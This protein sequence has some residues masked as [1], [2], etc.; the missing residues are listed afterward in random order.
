[1]SFF[2]INLEYKSGKSL[3]S[4][5]RSAL[6]DTI[7][8]ALNLAQLPK[9]QISSDVPYLAIDVTAR[10]PGLI[11]FFSFFFLQRSFTLSHG[12]CRSVSTFFLKFFTSLSFLLS[13]ETV[14]DLR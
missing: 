10:H 12:C 2:K 13:N 8:G 3:S 1:M 11:F 6:D 7:L 4:S 5:S 9:M 14:L